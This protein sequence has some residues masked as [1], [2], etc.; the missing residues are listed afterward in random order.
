MLIK[1]NTHIYNMKLYK[2]INTILLLRSSLTVCIS[3]FLLLSGSLSPL[4]AFQTDTT[5]VENPVL[6]NLEITG[7]QS[8]SRTELRDGKVF[9]VKEYTY[10]LQPVELG[11]GYIDGIIIEYTDIK[12]GVKDYLITQRMSVK[13]LI[14]VYAKDYS[15]IWTGVYLL[16]F[17]GFLTGLIF[18]IRRRRQGKNVIEIQPALIENTT[19]ERLKQ[20]HAQNNFSFSRKL[21][22]VIAEFRHFLIKKFDIPQDRKSDALIIETITESGIEENIIKKIHAI[23]IQ[24]EQIRFSGKDIENDD[25]ELVYGA[26]ESCIESCVKI[27]Y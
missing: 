25:F 14:P 20:V 13:G 6:T 9:A 16:A 2:H 27:S 10:S 11:M 12:T 26:V 22:E 24:A 21:D 8:S 3:F 5:A 1:S 19:I 23:F 17:A 7:S 18:Y 15:L 4:K